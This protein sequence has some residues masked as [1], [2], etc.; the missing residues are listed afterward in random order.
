LGAARSAPVCARSGAGSDTA[1][2]RRVRAPSQGARRVAG[3]LARRR[4]RLRPRRPRPGPRGA[5]RARPPGRRA[6]RAPGPR[7]VPR[8]RGS[9]GRMTILAREL[10]PAKINL[11]LYLG[12]TR[13]DRRHEL[14][15]LFDAVSLFDELEVAAAAAD[16]VV[17]EGVAGPNLVGD[18]LGA[19]R[20]AGWA[21]PA[22]RVTITKRI[23]VAAGM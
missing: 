18:A 17:C 10:A 12:P 13:D 8:A 6:R 9:A 3:A 11:C 15:T 5:R 23:P 16:E 22:L 7:G 2:A 20:G 1:R 4:R 14:V 19:L 21:A